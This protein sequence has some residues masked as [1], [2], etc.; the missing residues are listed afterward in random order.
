MDLCFKKYER[1]SGHNYKICKFA[2]DGKRIEPFD[3]PKMLEMEQDD[4]IDVFNEYQEGGN[5]NT[6]NRRIYD[7]PTPKA[8]KT[9]QKIDIAVQDQP[10]AKLFFRMNTNT[11]MEILMFEV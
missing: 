8:V 9:G 2:F 10:G 11:F 4:V 5:G 7:I 6:E 1:R 3:T